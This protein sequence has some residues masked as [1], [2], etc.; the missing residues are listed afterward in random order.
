MTELLICLSILLL[1]DT[2]SKIR[3]HQEERRLEKE[4]A[5]LYRDF[6]EQMF[7]YGL[8]YD[9]LTENDFLE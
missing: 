7:L 2:L 1:G 6:Y 5:E 8:D 4:T 9:Y 3:Q